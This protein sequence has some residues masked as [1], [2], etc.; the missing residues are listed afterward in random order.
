MKK[1]TAILLVLAMLFACGCGGGKNDPKDDRSDAI[2]PAEGEEAVTL[3]DSTLDQ[4]LTLT[5]VTTESREDAADILNLVYSY[6]EGLGI[7]AKIKSLY[8]IPF[9]LAGNWEEYI[10]IK[11]FFD[12]DVPPAYVIVLRDG[13]KYTPGMTAMASF[14]DSDVSNSEYFNKTTNCI[15]NWTGNLKKALGFGDSDHDVNFPITMT[16]DLSFALPS[17]SDKALYEEVVTRYSRYMLALWNEDLGE[18]QMIGGNY[19]QPL[20]RDDI[21]KKD[22]FH[23]YLAA[24]FTEDNISPIRSARSDL[25]SGEYP[26]Y[27]E[28]DGRIYVAPIGMGGPENLEG[29]EIKYS[30]QN[31]NYLF[32]I[33]EATRVERNWDTWE[34][35]SRHYEE[36]IFIYEKSGDSWLCDYFTDIPFGFYSTMM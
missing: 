15:D 7:T 12:G 35:I 3:Y 30:A 36:Y 21:R 19:Y 20:N 22:D 6:L 16:R 2:K 4:T 24:I 28:S 13:T 34:V 26:V 9:G 32:H 1:I 23:D 17:D 33:M 29:V 14:R 11:V 18:A 31:G 10:P 25:E 27:Y 5:R 8:T